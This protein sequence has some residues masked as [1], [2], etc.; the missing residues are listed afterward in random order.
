MPHIITA[1]T[2]TCRHIRVV[3]AKT[4]T[5]LHVHTHTHTHTHTHYTTRL[6]TGIMVVAFVFFIH[7]IEEM[8]WVGGWEEGRKG[9]RGGWEGGR[10]GGRENGREGEWEGGRDDFNNQQQPHEE[11]KYTL[12]VMVPIM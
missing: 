5:H 1:H 6:S 11:V 9:G 10:M 2:H 3:Y 7:C 8:L 12:S 4:C